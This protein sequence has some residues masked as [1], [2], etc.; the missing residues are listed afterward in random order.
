[1]QP[2]SG[3]KVVELGQNL[4]GPYAGF[5]L[6]ALGAEVLKVERPG[7][8][9]DARGWG[10]P[11]IGES[12]AIF[13]A[14]NAN[15]RSVT[16]DLKDPGQIEWLKRR[17]GGVDVV[18]QNLRPGVVERLGLDGEGLVA[19]NPRL[20]YCAVRAF[21]RVG[22]MKHVPGYEPMV[23]AIS[24]LMMVSGEEGAPPYRIGTH[25]LDHG[26]GMWAA[27]GI[28]A[29]LWQRARTGRGC[30]VD[31]SL[32][33]TA[34]GWLAT[35]FARYEAGGGLPQ[36]HPTGSNAVVVFQAFETSNG[37]LVIA[38]AN[39]RLFGKLAAALGRP[40]WARDPR[41]ARN[42]DRVAHRD[43]LL[44]AVQE[45]VGRDSKGA[46]IDR[47]E[48]AGVPCAPV[49]TLPEVLAMPQTAALGMIQQV[50]GLAVPL[51]SLPLSFDGVRPALR[52][53]APTVGADDAEKGPNGEEQ[54]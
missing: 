11:F 39:D 42:A 41:Y 25:I 26:T 9:D 2:L 31:T 52:S 34:L 5:I 29:G 24:S 27:M 54:I 49:N 18:L 44:P 4:A 10:P 17:I 13:N 19:A 14:V 45:I 23:Q 21:G 36:R 40:E 7:G 50:P 35:H 1:M 37:P 8:G 22:P 28:L 12:S 16:V 33:E 51:M 20:V 38:A 3:I 46:W 32:F 53:P 15:K 47:L 43:E 30:V 48:A 6:A